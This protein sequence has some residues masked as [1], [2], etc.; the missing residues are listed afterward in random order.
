ML[1]ERVRWIR[2]GIGCPVCG[3]YERRGGTL[4]VHPITLQRYYLYLCGRRG[5]RDRVV[6]WQGAAEARRHRAVTDY[7]HEHRLIE[8]FTLVEGM[9]PQYAGVSRATLRAF[10]DSGYEA[11]TVGGGS[12]ATLNGSIRS[13]GFA[14]SVY[15]EVRSGSAVLRRVPQVTDQAS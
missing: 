10:L 1:A 4:V 2:D 13:L 15:A 3:R 5:C 11:A 6:R 12:A 8:P 14:G 9:P 7:E